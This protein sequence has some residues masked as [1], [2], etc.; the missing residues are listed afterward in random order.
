MCTGSTQDLLH[1]SIEFS[2][3]VF[4]IFVRPTS[5]TKIMTACHIDG[6]R[7]KPDVFK[8]AARKFKITQSVSRL[9]GQA[10]GFKTK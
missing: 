5:T 7:E 3:N 1:R 4:I 10:V 2:S 6:R 8:S 9:L